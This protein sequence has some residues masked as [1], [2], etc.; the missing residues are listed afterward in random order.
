MRWCGKYSGLILRLCALLFIPGLIQVASGEEGDQAMDGLFTRYP[1]S[2][3]QE[4]AGRWESAKQAMIEPAEN[5]ILPL[6]HFSNGRLRAQLRAG[7]AQIFADGLIFA[8]D[9]TVE[10]FDEEGRADGMLKAEGCVFDRSKK[11]GYCEGNVSMEKDGDRLS[12]RG[13][14]FSFEGQF[15]KILDN[16]A[17]YTRRFKG[18]FGR[19]R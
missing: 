7:K 9:L 16:C 10:M 19:I 1:D 17:I 11:H 12:G 2:R 6:D 3:W 13:M 14:Y 5:I 8:E 15:I 18:N 4:L